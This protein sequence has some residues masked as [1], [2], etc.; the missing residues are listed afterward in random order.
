MAKT[1]HSAMWYLPEARLFLKELHAALQPIG[2]SVGLVGS[3]LLKGFSFKDLDVIIFPDSTAK[4]NDKGLRKALVKF[5]LKLQYDRAS[6]RN[7]W[8]KLGN[9]DTK[10]V[11]VWEYN[12]QRI[13]L[14]F[15]N[16]EPQ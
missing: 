16:C 11:E 7:A 4:L 8:K 2:Y 6:V 14:F 13:D 1:K 3:V 12:G 15:F 9:Y 10:H 5:G